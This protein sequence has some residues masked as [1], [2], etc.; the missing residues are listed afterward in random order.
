MTESHRLIEELADA[1]KRAWNSPDARSLQELQ[2][3]DMALVAK[4]E[5]YLMKTESLSMTEPRPGVPVPP[6]LK[7]QA[8]EDLEWLRK[9]IYGTGLGITQEVNQRL[10]RIRRALEALPDDN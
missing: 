4:A 5:N 9:Q 1:I 3:L 10:S 7:K 8:N 6:S 2:A